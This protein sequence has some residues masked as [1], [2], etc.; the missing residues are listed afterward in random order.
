ML[1]ARIWSLAAVAVLLGCRDKP[2]QPP[3]MA[4]VMPNV[5]LPPNPTLVSKS[6]GAN[7]LM[8]TFRTAVKPRAVEAYYQEVLTGPG[9]RLVKH[10]TDRSGAV[11]MLAEQDG[12]P[13]WVRIRG[14]PDSAGTLVDLAGAVVA[15]D[16]AAR[17]ARPGS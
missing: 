8:L 12:P 1:P 4:V 7:A 10:T 6:G 16:S 11:T 9:W 15:A 13:L 5:P 3:D 2:P 14:T 17:A